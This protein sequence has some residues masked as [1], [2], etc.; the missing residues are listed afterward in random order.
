MPFEFG[1]PLGV[2]DNADFQHRV[3]TAA[4][5]LLERKDGPVFDVFNEEAPGRDDETMECWSCP[6]TFAKKASDETLEQ[7]VLNEIRLLQPWFDKGKNERGYTSFGVSEMSLD[8]I[9]SF[10]VSFLEDTPVSAK[11]GIKYSIAD[12]LKYAAEDLKAFH[13]ESAMS[14]PGHATANEIENWY[15]GETA[16]GRLVRE[17]KQSCIDHADPMVSIVTAF[18][19]VP[20]RQAFRD[21]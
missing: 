5:N 20:H 4:L 21:G 2:P 3:L 1:R 13:N 15:W 10:L 6:V 16:A 8:E 9:V 17:I 18:T 11:P 12:S 19:L 7:L 14:Q